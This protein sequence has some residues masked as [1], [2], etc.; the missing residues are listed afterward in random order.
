MPDRLSTRIGLAFA[1]VALL[2]LLGV[3]ATLFVVIRGLHADAA[4][5]ALAQTVQPLVFQLRAVNP[6]ANLRGLIADLREQVGEGVSVHLV[7]DDGRAIDALNEDAVL[8][9]PID[10]QAGVGVTTTG[11][12]PTADRRDRLYAA[13]TVRGPDTNGVRAIV[14]SELDTSAA[15]AVRDLGRTLVAVFGLV[16]LVGAPIGFLLARSVTGPL[17]RLAEATADLPVGPSRLLAE[18]GPAEVRELTRRFNAMAAE[19]AAQRAD[20]TRL[21]ADLR[22]DLR[23]P[24]TVIGGFA[25]ALSDGT[26]TGEDAGRAAGAIREEAARLERLLAELDTVERLRRGE[27]GLRPERIDAGEVITATLTRFAAAARAAGVTLLDG[28]DGSPRE[29]GVEDLVVAADRVAMDRILGNLVE[30]ALAAVDGPG[31]HVWLD[32]RA[33]P[34]VASRGPGVAFMVT[35]DGPGFPPGDAER[36]FERFYRGDASRSGTGTGLGLAIV[37]ELARAHGGDAIA[38]NVAPRGARISVILPRSAGPVGRQQAA[39]EALG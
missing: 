35:D 23:T 27:A 20:E 2:T 21:L 28:R 9:F 39:A 31:R 37:R 1:S 19:L 13:T 17:R 33:V 30:N 34:A 15:A 8:R 6:A 5:N 24:L 26:A 29:P 32:A 36:A 3:A 10:P 18:E 25:E 14:L 11:S 7:T 12:I 4:K 38:E 16:A 22:H